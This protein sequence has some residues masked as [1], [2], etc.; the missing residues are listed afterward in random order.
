[1]RH[2][3]IVAA[4]GARKLAGIMSASGSPEVLAEI[5]E[6]RRDPEAAHLA[7]AEQ[8]AASLAMAWAIEGRVLDRVSDAWE[9]GDATDASRATVLDELERLRNLV[10]GTITALLEA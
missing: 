5:R 1:T 8:L 4:D 10:D 9:R 6:R 2:G 3:P 7:A